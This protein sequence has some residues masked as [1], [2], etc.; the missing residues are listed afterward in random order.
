M[1]E[2]ASSNHDLVAHFSFLVGQKE[3]L[4]RKLEKAEI[5]GKIGRV[6]MYRC[7]LKAAQIGLDR[8]RGRLGG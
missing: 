2:L 1:L 8:V 4:Q 5:G 6:A 7:Q 3:N